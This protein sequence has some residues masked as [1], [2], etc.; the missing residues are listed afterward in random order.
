MH[1]AGLPDR[2]AVTARIHRVC[3]SV[4]VGG[5]VCGGDGL[6]SDLR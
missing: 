6:F 2:N 1:C 4:F 3:C 5:R